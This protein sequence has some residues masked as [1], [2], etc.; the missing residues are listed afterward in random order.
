VPVTSSPQIRALLDRA[1]KSA[2]R[3]PRCATQVAVARGGELLAFETF[4][5]A[6]FSADVQAVRAADNDTLFSIYSV[7][8]AITSAATWI[9]L[10]DGKIALGDRVAHAIPELG[11]HGKDVVTVEQ[12]LVH[13]AGFPSARFACG[14]WPDPAR[15]S[16]RFASWKLEWPPGSRF[17]YHG[18]STMWALA[19]LITR[20]AGLDYRDFIR[21]R[22]CEPLGLGNLHVGL[23][24]ALHGRVADVIALGEPMSA[25]ESATSPVDA[26]VIDE[27]MLGY[28]N[29]P[30]SRR[31]GGPGG[32]AIATASD[33]ALFYQALLA[34]AEQRGP[35]V[36][37][38]A[39]LQDAWRVR[40]PELIDGMTKQ[41][42]LRGL[43]VVVAGDEGRMWRGFA[44]R[45]SARAFGHMGAGGQ[46][47][48]ADP[49]TGLSFVFLT[50]GAQQ[51]PARQ[52]ANGFRLSTL[53]AEIGRAAA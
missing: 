30:E 19:A 43:G 32:G 8:K 20:V 44:E 14:D 42:A 24:D 52:G 6:P 51:N 27:A 49:E 1:E 41:P 31:I 47:S 28:A 17:V 10:Q 4:G 26:P 48:W 35:G 40:H 29:D 37:R 9:L 25:E 45:C 39:T 5:H 38:A 3:D 21:T 34:D 50:N 11:S 22:I 36:W 46:I 23:P 18:S 13:T 12:C 7:T 33:V 16:E 2:S 53:A 15:R